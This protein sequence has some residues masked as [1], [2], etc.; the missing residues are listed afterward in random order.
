M[1]LHL[2][3][4]LNLKVLY[5]YH[6]IDLIMSYQLRLYLLDIVPIQLVYVT[7]LFFFFFEPC[8]KQ[9]FQPLFSDLKLNVLFCSRPTHMLYLD[10][11]IIF[12]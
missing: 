5:L 4:D 11:Y 8:M 10:L 9:V 6:Q 1:L 3:E 7:M 2:D 12:M